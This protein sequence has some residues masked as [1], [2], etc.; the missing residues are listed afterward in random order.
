MP[1]DREN[2]PVG[3][4][5]ENNHVKFTMDTFDITNLYIFKKY[6]IAQAKV[7]LAKL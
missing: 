4:N 1:R 2:K 3:L 5:Q 7:A 6:Y